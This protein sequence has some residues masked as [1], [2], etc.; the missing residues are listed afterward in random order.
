MVLLCYPKLKFSGFCAPLHSPIILI[1]H[2]LTGNSQVI[3]ESGWWNDIV[4]VDKTIDTR[5]YVSFDVPGMVS[6][7]LQ[8]K[9]IE[10]LLR[11]YRIFIEGLRV[12]KIDT[13][14][15]LIGGSVGGGIAWEILAGA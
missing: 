2:A 8:L 3:G 5:K 4:G 14:F 10:I 6:I 12:L 7:Q 9:I 1:N 11:E 13:L 15:A